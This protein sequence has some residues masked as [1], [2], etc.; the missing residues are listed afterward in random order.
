MATSLTNPGYYS[1]TVA[2]NMFI[3]MSEASQTGILIPTYNTT[4]PTFGLWNPSG[5][6]KNAVL[7]RLT[8]GFVS[9]TGAPGAILYARLLSASNTTYTGGPLTAFNSTTPGNAL[10]GAGAASAMKFA[11]KGTNTL[12]TAGV[13]FDQM[14]VSQLTTT[15]AT[16]SAPLYSAI[17]DFD[18][19]IIVPPG[20][21]FYVVGSTALL[22]LF[23][24][25]LSWYEVP[26]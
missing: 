8:T 5:S 16:T 14:G 24:M 18:G 10:L 17:D 12:T 4:S 6:G 20:V 26:V 19:R 1:Q 23:D 11:G 9:T 7:V 25:S 13:V 15:G 2:G 3:G 21:F 22:T